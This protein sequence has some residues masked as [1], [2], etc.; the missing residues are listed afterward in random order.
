MAMP[1][2]CFTMSGFMMPPFVTLGPLELKEASI[3][4]GSFSK[5]VCL[6]MMVAVGTRLEDFA[7]LL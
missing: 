3:G 4:A 5:S 7:A 6:N 2:L 1:L